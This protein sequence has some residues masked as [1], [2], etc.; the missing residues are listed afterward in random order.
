[1]LMEPGRGNEGMG[2]VM[3]VAGSGEIFSASAPEMGEKGSAEKAAE[4]E[5]VAQQGMPIITVPA[6]TS[7]DD[8][9]SAGHVDITGDN[10]E[11][12]RDTG[13]IEKE[14]VNRA[15]KIITETKDDPHERDDQVRDLKADYMQKRFNRKI[16]DRN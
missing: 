12:A 14:W 9:S 4:G 8:T 11:T 10:P 15:R 13:K 3:P 1:M 2:N 16:G 5:P 6:P 7:A